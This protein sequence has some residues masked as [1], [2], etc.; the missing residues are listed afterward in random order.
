MGEKEVKIQY[1]LGTTP[2][3]KR[4]QNLL[5][6]FKLPAATCDFLEVL[7]EASQISPDKLVDIAMRRFREE[8][9]QRLGVDPRSL[10]EDELAAQIRSIAEEL[11]KEDEVLWDKQLPYA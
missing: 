2:W 3:V 1:G 8:I 11:C 9:T 5:R 6:E 10:S 7:S 4:D